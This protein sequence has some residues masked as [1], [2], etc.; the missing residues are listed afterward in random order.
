MKDEHRRYVL[1]MFALGIIPTLWVYINGVDYFK[2]G[3]IYI[4][5]AL[6]L[7]VIYINGDKL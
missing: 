6:I 4:A 3:A 2:A 5:I 1:L 7:L